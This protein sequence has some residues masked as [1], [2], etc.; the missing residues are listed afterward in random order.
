MSRLIEVM[1][2][3]VTVNGKAD[4]CKASGRGERMIERYIAGQAV[5]STQ[6]KY[7][8][9]R[10]CGLNHEEAIVLAHEASEADKAS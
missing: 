2:E 10:Q 1:K 7:K 6:V 3:Y 4:L 9:A 5:P 8:L